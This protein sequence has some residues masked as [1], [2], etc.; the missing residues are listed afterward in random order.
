MPASNK[1]P[2]KELGG[3]WAESRSA[4]EGGQLGALSRGQEWQF[5]MEWW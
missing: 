2:L 5:Q 3:L 1:I 4:E